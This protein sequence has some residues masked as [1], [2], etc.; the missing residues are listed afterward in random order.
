[1]LQDSMMIEGFSDTLA[2]HL[3]YGNSATT[4]AQF[5]G[6]ATRY[7][8][9]GTQTYTTAAQVID[10]GGT[11]SDNTSIYLV[12]WGEGKVSGIYPK[13]TKAGLQYEDRGIENIL[14]NSTTGAYMRAYVSW[15]QWMC[16]LA[17]Y[18]YRYVV[19]ICNIDVS[20]LNTASDSSDTSANIL[21]FMSKAL[22]LLP[23]D[24]NVQPVFYMTRNTKSMLRVKLDNKSNLFLRMED[25]MAPAGIY[26]RPE[27]TYQ[28]IPCRRMDSM[29]ETE[30]QI[31]TAT[32]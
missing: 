19:R 22:D 32:T 9:L 13:G 21:K 15:M 25:I 4:A 2:T 8:S 31:T 3:I 26:R 6:F 17:V 5:N 20:N 28:G 14:T 10:A 23:D 1:M 12:G 16:G 11:G 29:L 7:F 18:D 30:A 27:L 24:G